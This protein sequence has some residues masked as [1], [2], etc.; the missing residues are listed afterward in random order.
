MECAFLKHLQQVS[1]I[2]RLTLTIH[3]LSNFFSK[4]CKTGKKIEK[5]NNIKR[6]ENWKQG[7]SGAARTGEREKKG[8]S[9]KK[10]WEWDRR[11]RGKMSRGK[12]NRDREKNGDKTDKYG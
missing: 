4:Y 11:K 7:K 9:K 3:F 5:E 1:I 6:E 8:R 2:C 12:R 10:E